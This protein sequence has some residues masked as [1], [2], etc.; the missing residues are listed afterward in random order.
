MSIKYINSS[1]IFVTGGTGP[2]GEAFL[3]YLNSKNVEIEILR[4]PYNQNDNGYE[5][6]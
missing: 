1:K 6:R 2:F 5:S 4:M 3:R